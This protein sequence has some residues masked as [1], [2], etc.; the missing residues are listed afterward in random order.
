MKSIKMIVVTA[1]ISLF[2]A[3]S[4]AA[5]YG[6]A[7]CGLGAMIFKDK[8]GKIQIL[9]GYLNMLGAQTFAITSGTS[10]CGDSGVHSASNYIKVNHAALQTDIARGNGEALA[11]LAKL[12][13]CSNTAEFSQTLKNNFE[14]IYNGSEVFENIQGVVRSDNNLSKSCSI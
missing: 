8:P 13:N 12:Y 11:G 5:A 10:Q 14:Q 2:G 3:T 4:F 6:T 1:A 7:G 9:S